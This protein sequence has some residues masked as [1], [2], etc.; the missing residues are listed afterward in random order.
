MHIKGTPE[1]YE[2]QLNYFCIFNLDIKKQQEIV[3]E[4]DNKIKE[5]QKI[6]V[7]IEKERNKI[8][9]IINS[10]INK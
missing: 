1:I 8:Y 10:Y 6:N 5:Q 9:D 4:I 7:Q 2:A 3:D